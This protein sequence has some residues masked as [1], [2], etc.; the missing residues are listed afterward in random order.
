VSKI[1]DEGSSALVALKDIDL[2]ITPGEFVCVLGPSGRAQSKRDVKIELPYPRDS[3]SVAFND[4]K[5]QLAEVVHAEHDRFVA[6][7]RAG[8]TLD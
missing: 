3:N 7:E 6:D 8:K 2:K 5:R 4:V 1:F